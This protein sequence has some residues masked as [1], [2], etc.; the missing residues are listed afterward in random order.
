M[1]KDL[2]VDKGFLRPDIKEPVNHFEKILNN[3]E[4]NVK[5]G[6][7]DEIKT[8][9]TL[10]MLK[11]FK[12]VYLKKYPQIQIPNVKSIGSA[13][14]VIEIR[15][16]QR[17]VALIL[18]KEFDFTTIF[19]KQDE[20]LEQDFQEIN[21]YIES[22]INAI[23]ESDIEE[24]IKKEVIAELNIIKEKLSKETTKLQVVNAEL[25][26]WTDKL[27][28]KN[29]EPKTKKLLM[30]IGT[31]TFNK[32]RLSILSC[33]PEVKEMKVDINAKISLDWKR[34]KDEKEEIIDVEVE[35]K[36]QIE[37]KEEQEEEEV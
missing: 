26:S 32:I 27:L 21:E 22:L 15:K 1:T 14:I 33:I 7:Y 19:K 36:N 4:S 35:E 3:F 6:L 16:L 30:E 31:K 12:E 18:A 8:L 24:S 5:Q 25:L 28:F 10:E 13:A 11:G 20:I 29:I 17:E 2:Y 23:N 9:T 34:T 37:N